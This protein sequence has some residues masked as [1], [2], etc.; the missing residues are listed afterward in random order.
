MANDTDDFTSKIVA[1]VI[2]V[3]VIA[4]VAIPIISGF[5]KDPDGDGPQTAT[6]TDGTL[7]TII[8]VIPIFLVL[9]V[10]MM[11]VYLFLQKRSN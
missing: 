5:T 9:A 2:C 10:L 8:N 6:I 4:A 11:V 1:V 7:V 3:I